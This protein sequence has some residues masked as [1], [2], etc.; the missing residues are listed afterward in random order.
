MPRYVPSPRLGYGGDNW[1]GPVR[2]DFMFTPWRKKKGAQTSHLMLT[3]SSFLVTRQKMR[4]SRELS[5]PEKI[6]GMLL[7]PAASLLPV[8]TRSRDELTY[9][10]LSSPDA[11]DD[12]DLP[13][14]SPS[15]IPR[16]Q[17]RPRNVRAQVRPVGKKVP[18]GSIGKFSHRNLGRRA[19]K[20]SEADAPVA[21]VIGDEAAKI[22]HE[23]SGQQRIRLNKVDSP[24]S[25]GKSA[26]ENPGAHEGDKPASPALTPGAVGRVRGNLPPAFLSESVNPEQPPAAQP[27]PRLPA[28]EVITPILSSRRKMPTRDR[29]EYRERRDSG[30]DTAA[31]APQIAPA[32]DSS[33]E[34]RDQ[35]G[36]VRADDPGVVSGPNV[37]DND[38]GLLVKHNSA[39]VSELRSVGAETSISG[40]MPATPATPASQTPATPATPAS[41]TPATPVA[42]G[43]TPP[44]S[45]TPATP[46]ATGPTP[47][48]LDSV[49]VH[50]D[51]DL[52]LDGDS[53][54]MNFSPGG[55]ENRDQQGRVRADDPGVVSGPNVVDNDSGLLVKHNSA[56]VSE[57]RSV[58]AETSI[59]GPMPATPATPASQA[60]ATPAS[61][62]RATPVATGPTAPTAPTLDSG[63]MNFSPGGAANVAAGSEGASFKG[64]SVLQRR[65]LRRSGTG[66]V[67]QE[68]AES[69]AVQ[70]KGVKADPDVH[71]SYDERSDSD[72]TTRVVTSASHTLPKNVVNAV[73]KSAGSSPD[74]VEVLRGPA[75]DS[76]AKSISAEAYTE[77][78][79]VHIPGKASLDSRANQVLLAHE[80]TH[81]VQQRAGALPLEHTSGGQQLEAQAL[82]AETHVTGAR[83]T[84]PGS[85][86]S[87]EQPRVPAK[88]NVPRAISHHGRSQSPQPADSEPVSKWRGSNGSAVFGVTGL[89][90]L[91]SPQE[92]SQA[93]M[94]SMGREGTG[95]DQAPVV[96]TG[97]IHVPLEHRV[98]TQS[99]PQ[100]QYNDSLSQELSATRSGSGDAARRE[101]GGISV[102]GSSSGRGVLQRRAANTPAPVVDRAPT[103]PNP[104]R[105]KKLSPAQARDSVRVESSA[106]ATDADWL[107]RHSRALYPLIR[108]LLRADL[109]R[110]RER[111]SK[112]M[113]EY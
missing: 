67:A 5:A 96:S 9:A 70:G 30:L 83:V 19:V 35:Q 112:M 51:S 81:L 11:G 24:P 37:V 100:N 40:P 58:G 69:V 31:T 27:T 61:P 29:L 98:V 55:A 41:Q 99:R 68:D 21:G 88:S 59:S 46:V 56:G 89:A 110:D 108:D 25:Q 16:D 77:N 39:G 79:Q 65:A 75:V 63:G 26:P 2:G 113:R 28:G 104:P 91:T 87:A 4:I 20:L 102:S 6:Q 34:N 12:L 14:V 38:S 42:T 95:P 107:D 90:K 101:T 53:G 111:R 93:G 13:N 106:S 80:V 50:R 8:V 84:Q 47:P 49:L 32:T 92:P 64:F 15:Q 18:P 94:T 57:L 45:Q 103:E 52:V 78:G 54:G 23:P 3:P 109:L 1:H 73:A 7:R 97:A 22:A 85:L 86:P 82:Q 10:D 62:I 72:S 71:A 17:D 74:S 33:A 43:P 76:R 60:P 48:T 36:P 105:V 44:T 66:F